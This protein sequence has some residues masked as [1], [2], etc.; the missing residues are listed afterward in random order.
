MSGEI[1]SSFGGGNPWD[2]IQPWDEELF[3]K[4]V[5]DSGQRAK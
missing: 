3:G 5:Y 2:Y 1:R 4:D